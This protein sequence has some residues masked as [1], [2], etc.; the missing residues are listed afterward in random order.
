VRK[1]KINFILIVL[2]LIFT[3]N[4]YCAENIKIK[5]V[6]LKT[7]HNK[8]YVDISLNKNIPMEIF[9]L[10]RDGVRVTIV[11][12][13]ELYRVRPFFLF[14]DENIVSQQYKIKIHYRLWENKY[15]LKMKNKKILSFTST[16]KL[17]TFLKN[18]NDIFVIDKKK[19]Q[20]GERYYLKTKVLCKSVELYPPFKWVVDIVGLGKFE[21]PWY[22]K[23]IK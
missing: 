18:I 14:F 16:K 10:L 2:F 9:E 7:N 5:K 8:L 21:T 17:N 12:V 11:Y 23:K 22:E 1:I 6:V 15:Y 4:I 13:V 3:K 20:K 19:L